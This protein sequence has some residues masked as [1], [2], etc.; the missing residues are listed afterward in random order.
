V[1]HLGDRVSAYVDGQLPIS[2]TERVTAHLATCSECREAVER[3]RSIKTALTGMDE[4]APEAGFM[5][6]LMA[7]GGPTGPMTPRDQ[8]MPGSPRPPLVMFEANVRGRPELSLAPSVPSALAPLTRGGRRR[9]GGALIVGA[10]VVGA[11]FLTSSF[12]PLAGSSGSPLV[13]PATGQLVVSPGSSN[14]GQG[15]SRR[16]GVGRGVPPVL[17]I[18]GLPV[19]GLSAA[20]V[21]VAGISFDFRPSDVAFPTLSSSSATPPR[22]AR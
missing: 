2:H 13:R 12:L 22:P 4:P 10:T 5:I 15:A 11:G 9:L 21:S 20:G 6:A 17:P 1:T 19:A 18:T 14:S 3:E 8:H 16:G 7:L